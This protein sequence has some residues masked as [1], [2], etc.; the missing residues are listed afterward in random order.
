MIANGTHNQMNKLSIPTITGPITIACIKLGIQ[1]IS[2]LNISSPINIGNTLIHPN[3]I[4][5]NI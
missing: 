1:I 5:T 2:D 3:D 4:L